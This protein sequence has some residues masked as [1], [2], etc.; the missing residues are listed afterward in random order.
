MANEHN[1][2]STLP[3]E[4]TADA[5]DQN[6][7]SF[8]VLSSADSYFSATADGYEPS[9]T[10]F[11]TFDNRMTVHPIAIKQEIQISLEVKLPMSISTMVSDNREYIKLDI[12]DPISIEL[13]TLNMNQSIQLEFDNSMTIEIAPRS[14][15]AISLEVIDA[16][17]DIEISPLFKQYY[18]L[19]DWDGD[20]L[21]TLDSEY[22]IDLD[23][24]LV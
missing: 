20:Y 13:N 11:L 1:F 14:L 16:G 10:I 6:V 24:Q 19:E 12:N 5:T 9:D 18:K 21:S 7:H 8:D 23:Y 2:G 17:I 3:E 15:M 22:L 4:S